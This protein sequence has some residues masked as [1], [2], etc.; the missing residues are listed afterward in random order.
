MGT[1]ISSNPAKI[2]SRIA[3]STASESSSRPHPPVGRSCTA[4]PAS[5][6]A[7]MANS[8]LRF[9]SAAYEIAASESAHLG[10]LRFVVE[11]SQSLHGLLHDQSARARAVE[12]FSQ[13][14]VWDTEHN[15]GVLIYV[16]L[17]DRR[18]EIVADRGIN[19]RVEEGFWNAI[20]RR[21]EAAYRAGSFEQGTLL[22]LNDVTAVLAEHFPAT[23][24]NPDEL[25]NAPVI[26]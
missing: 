16:Q 19:A 20:C 13:L 23:G 11:A 5:R 26:R 7:R 25:P 17:V 15:S 3:R 18:V 6:I 14:G 1:T 10:E 22:A 21:I 24:D 9:G 12:L 4:V 8:S 2:A